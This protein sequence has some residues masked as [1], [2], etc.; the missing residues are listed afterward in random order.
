MTASGASDAWATGMAGFSSGGSTLRRARSH[1]LQASDCSHQRG[2]DGAGGAAG[3]AR[4]VAGTLSATG[5]L[6]GG[7]R[8]MPSGPDRPCGPCR[9]TSVRG[10]SSLGD[11]SGSDCARAKRS[12]AGGRSPA[13]VRVAVPAREA[14]SVASS[15]WLTGRAS[16]RCRRASSS[17]SCCRV[18]PG[19][20]C[21]R[22]EFGS[23]MCETTPSMGRLPDC[24]FDTPPC[25]G[26]GR[27]AL[28][29]A[30]VLYQGWPNDFTSTGR[31]DR[32]RS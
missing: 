24:R 26:T 7:S 15:P 12:G 1:R 2:S 17:S 22:R 3:V 25:T 27:L 29:R 21:R 16:M 18:G 6:G 10:G 11:S 13:S 30:G 5:G 23:D 31:W 28:R 8:G 32:A 14:G 20:R 19:K 4:G 9:T